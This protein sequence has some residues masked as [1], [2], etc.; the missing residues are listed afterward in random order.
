[1]IVLTRLALHSRTVTVLILILVLAGGIFRLTGSCSRNFSPR[2]ACELSTSPLP[3]S[4]AR[5]TRL[6]RR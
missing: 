6:R 4:K 1:M 3:T 5:R 2:S